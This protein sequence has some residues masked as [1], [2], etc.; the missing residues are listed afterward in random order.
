METRANYV[1]IGVFTLAVVVGVFGF[2][3]WFQNIGGTGERAYYRIVFDGSVSGLR[4]GASVL[5]NGI[6]VGE[7]TG[8]TLDSKRPKQVVARI[9]VDKSVAIREDTEI[10]LEFQGLTGISALSLKGGNPDKPPLIG[11]AKITDDGPLLVAPPGAT[12]DVTQAARDALRKVQEFI[13]DNQ[14]AFKNALANI[15]SFTAAL[16]RNSENVDRTL[17]S[18][19]KFTAALGRNSENV[20]K[21][22]ASIEQFTGALAR[23]SDRIDRIAAGLE[24]LTGGPDGKGGDINEAARSIKELADNLDKR[25][26]DLTVGILRLTNSG[27]RALSTIDKAAKNFDANPSRLI[28]GGPPPDSKPKTKEPR[29]QQSR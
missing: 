28:W 12:Q 6:R 4:T 21:T 2:I 7:V 13:E 22:L 24:N 20:D 5:F 11:A 19:E 18:V 10:G 25:T 27:T 9:S 3:Y 8:L 14:T 23:T 1:L 17:T 15:D 29:V 16:A 26:A